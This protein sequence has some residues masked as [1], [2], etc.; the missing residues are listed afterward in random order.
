VVLVVQ[1]LGVPK[2]RRV[3][4]EAR[5]LASAGYRV[6]VVAPAAPGEA[7]REHL[8]GVDIRRYRRGPGRAGTVG[9]ILELVVGLAGTAWQLARL[10]IAGPVDVVHT[11]NPPDTTVLVACLLKWSG[12]TRFVYDQ[13]DL[14]PELLDLRAGEADGLGATIM[15]A[16]APVFRALEAASYRLADLV[17]TPNDSYRRVAMTRGRVPAAAAVTVRSGPDTVHARAQEPRTG[18]L[19]VAFAGV[20]GRQDRLDVLLDAAAALLERRPGAVR[21]DLIGEGD[22]VPR[23]RAR[24]EALGIADAV[25]WPGWLSGEDLEAR[26][27][28]A[29]VAVSLDDDNPFCQM[30]TMCKVPEY[31]ALGLP[32]VIADLVE[33][34]VTAAE[35]A[36]Y[37]QPGNAGELAKWL[38]ELLDDPSLLAKLGDAA[39]A[40]AP[41]LLWSASAPR[42]LAAYEWML[43]G[44]P[45]PAGDQTLPA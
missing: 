34:R 28:A 21:L 7:A 44:R 12:G 43:D 20:M 31:L 35:A 9:Q 1:N 14:V 11:A 37:Y 32:C 38:E 19:V 27:G 8:E 3:W 23:L 29:D 33:N 2:D 24:V 4:R 30:S 45:P 16:T 41:A 10:R 5:A 6:T 17:V 25:S 42:L 26:L 36:L 22:D 18:P 39:S 13:H 15:R 40:R